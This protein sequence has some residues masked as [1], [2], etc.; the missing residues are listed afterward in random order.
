MRTLAGIATLIATMGLVTACG[1]NKDIIRGDHAS[2]RST[3]PHAGSSMR[4][5][6]LGGSF[7]GGSGS[8]ERSSPPE[9]QLPAGPALS[10][11]PAVAAKPVVAEG[12]AEGSPWQARVSGQDLLSHGIAAN[13]QAPQGATVRSEFGAVKVAAG[14]RFNLEIHSAPADMTARKQEVQNNGMFR[15]KRY[16][17]DTAETLVY[18]VEAAESQGRSEFHFVSHVT[19]GGKTYRCEDTKGISYTQSEVQ[20]ML[21]ACR[22]MTPR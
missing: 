10:R 5:S 19:V 9:P 18:E 2:S 6:E 22:S 3:D 8:G 20:A 21:T 7:A 1:S 11:A 15:F 13:I 17:V 4:S 14:P 12:P 16:T